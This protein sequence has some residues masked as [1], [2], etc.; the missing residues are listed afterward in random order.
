MSRSIFIGR[1]AVVVFSVFITASPVIAATP[2][3]R[4]LASQCFQCHGANGKSVSG[5]E[6]ISGESASEI[7]SELKEMQAKASSEP[8]IMHSQAKIYTDEE[9]KALAAYLSKLPK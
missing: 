9:I 2:N 5:I 3:G 6:G 8:D 7:F 1:T 4:L